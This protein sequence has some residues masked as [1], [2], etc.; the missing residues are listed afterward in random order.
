[1][2]RIFIYLFLA[3]AAISPTIAQTVVIPEW[4]SEAKAAYARDELSRAKSL[5]EEVLATDPRNKTARKYLKTIASDETQILERTQQYKELILPHVEFHDATLEVVLKT[6]TQ[7]TSKISGGKVR[8]HFVVAFQK[9][10]NEPLITMDLKNTPF[11]EVLR[12]VGELVGVKVIV[13]P[14]MIVLKQIT[15]T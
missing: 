9:G 2:R 4:I 6:L 11:S 13:R 3:V 5:F 8:P 12:Y 1:M 7:E 15:S 10:D 14:T